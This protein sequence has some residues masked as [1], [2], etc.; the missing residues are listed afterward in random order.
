MFRTF[1][2]H[3]SINAC[4]VCVCESIIIKICKLCKVCLQTHGEPWDA[5]KQK[6]AHTERKSIRN[7]KANVNKPNALVQPRVLP[8]LPLQLCLQRCPLLSPHLVKCAKLSL[9]QRSAVLTAQLHLKSLQDIFCLCLSIQSSNDF[10]VGIET[11][12]ES[13][14]HPDST[15][16]QHN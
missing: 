10:L 9:Y 5:K 8:L 13:Y 1:Q 15:D 6:S 3:L 4:A 2:P 11:C 14:N 12:A 16:L 7:Q